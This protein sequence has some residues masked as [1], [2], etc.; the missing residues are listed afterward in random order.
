MPQAAI[1][2]ILILVA[3]NDRGRFTPAATVPVLLAATLLGSA[4]GSWRIAAIDSGALEARPGG[5]LELRGFTTGVAK[6]SRGLTRVPIQTE[7]GR[8]MVESARAPPRISTGSG[9][10]AEGVVRDP[11]DFYREMYARQGIRRVLQ[12]GEIRLDGDRRGGLPGW[13][14]SVRNRGESALGKGMPDRESALARGFVLG[15][16]DSIDES[17]KDDFQASGL[18][19]LLAVSGQNVVLLGLLAIP[20]MALAG[21]G[22]RARLACVAALILV[23][24]PLAGAGPSIQRAG[25]MGMAGLVAMSATRPA[26]RIYALALAAAVTLALNPRAGSDIGWQLSFAAVIGIFLMTGP[27]QVR[28]AR[29]VGRGGWRTGLVDGA[30]VTLAAT[31]ATAPLMAFHFESFPV[32]TL[33]ANLLALPAVAPAMWLGMVSAALGQISEWLALPFNWLNAPLLAYI[34]QVAAWCGGPSWTRLEVK[35]GGPFELALVYLALGALSGWFLWLTRP[36]DPERPELPGERRRRIV[37]GTAT[38]GALVVAILLVLVPAILE[39]HRRHLDAPPPGGVRIEVLDVGQGDAILIRPDDAEPVL[40]DGGPPG[41]DIEGALESAE[42]AR[43]A[44]V[45]LTHRHLDHFGGLYDVFEEY[46]VGHFLFDEVPPSLVTAARDAGATTARLSS[47]RS[48]AFGGV[49]AEVLWPR[50]K[51][52]GATAAEDPNTRSL[53]IEIE[54]GR[55]RML[56][57]GD[58]EAEAASVDPEPLDVLKVAHHGSD[59]AALPSLLSQSDPELALISVGEDNSYGHPAPGTVSE[60]N[61]A[62]AEVKRTDEEGT[63]SI[64]VNRSGYRVETGR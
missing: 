27:L 29:L 17:T 33:V 50:P 34:A 23:Y 4:A 55:F 20:F 19:H 54:A 14:D 16:D 62:G 48:F 13:I 41:G 10:V 31:I 43:L 8:I 2:L 42:V 6:H 45:F 3:L 21:F 18:A 53:V 5:E 26:S 36:P 63:I 12:A 39:G 64:V 7:D 30:A 58:A 15:Q 51:A 40:V 47:G 59:D 52:P 37:A 22:P 24:V 9:V 32:T 61:E 44:A 35:V 57:T 25:V 46:P 49:D 60:L 56:L 11:G 38:A 1:A 28:L